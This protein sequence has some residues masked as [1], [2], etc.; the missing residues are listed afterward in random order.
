MTTKLYVEEFGNGLPITLLHGYPLD[1]TIWMELVPQIE[2]EARLI[3][4]DLRGHGKSPAPQGPYSMLEMAEDVVG[5]W[6]SLGVEKSVIGGHSMG[7]YV[8]L[9]LARYFP[10]R[11]AGLTLVASRTN[12]DAPEKRKARL[13]S[14][15]DV[16]KNGI[17]DAILSMPE[18]LSYNKSVKKFCREIILDASQVGVMGVLAAMADRPDSLDLFLGLEIP[19]M[20]IAGQ[21]DQIVPIESLRSV[22]QKMKRPWLVEISNAGHMPMLEEPKEVA[23]ALLAFIQFIKENN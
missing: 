9:A 14:I 1:H 23:S 8:A 3:L 6:D 10:E 2:N 22:A 12:A 7:G 15:E 17:G 11:L 16:R 19:S 18:K 4:P 20:I 5:M 21:D 13:D